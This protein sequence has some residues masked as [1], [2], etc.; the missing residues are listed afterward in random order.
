ME[1][2]LRRDKRNG[3]LRGPDADAQ[4]HQ[5]CEGD[6]CTQHDYR[7]RRDF[8]LFSQVDLPIRA[9]LDYHLRDC[10]PFLNG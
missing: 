6:L 4:R 2:L 8:L 1:C 3:K 7:I 5:P 10:P 9:S